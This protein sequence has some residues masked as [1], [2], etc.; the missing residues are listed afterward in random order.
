M[1]AEIRAILSDAV[2]PEPTSPG[3]LAT[4]LHRFGDVGGVELDL[5]ARSNAP[6]AA[7]LE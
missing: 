2:S 1:E 6:R 4:I 3:L 7:D 5:P